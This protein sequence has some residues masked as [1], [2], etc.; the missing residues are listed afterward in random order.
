NSINQI[1]KEDDLGKTIIE[2]PRNYVTNEV[3]KFKSAILKL[4]ELI[5]PDINYEIEEYANRN[6][7]YFDYKNVFKN[8]EFVN[9]MS[10]RLVNDYIRLTRRN[11]SDKFELIFNSL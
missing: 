7:N 1:L 3:E 8:T 6:D 4:W 9:D 2:D 5:T 10:R 11:E